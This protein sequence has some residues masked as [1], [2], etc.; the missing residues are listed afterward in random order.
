MGTSSH[1]ANDDDLARAKKLLNTSDYIDIPNASERLTFPDLVTQLID[2]NRDVHHD[3]EPDHLVTPLA[4]RTHTVDVFVSYPSQSR[5]EVIPINNALLASGYTVFFDFEALQG[6]DEFGEVIDQQLKGSRSVVACWSPIS[7][8]SRWCRAEWRVG[9]H[10]GNLIPIVI[11][12]FTFEQIPTEFNGLQYID[13]TGFSGSRQDSCFVSL[14]KS[15][16]R[17]TGK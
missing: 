3:L 11:G 8:K 16:R 13:F 17:F 4:P 5:T 10:L 12:E 2:K 7:F 14:L 9:Q 15:I 6:G 1:E